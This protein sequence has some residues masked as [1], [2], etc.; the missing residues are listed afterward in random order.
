LI[1][2]EANAIGTAYLRI[3]ML[4]ANDQMEIRALFREYLDA[5]L[6]AFESLR[7]RGAARQ[8]FARAAEIQVQQG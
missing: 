7:N 4:P 2:N 3:D 1:V 5:R 6:S 8:E